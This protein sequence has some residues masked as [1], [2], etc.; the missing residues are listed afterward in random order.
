MNDVYKVYISFK[1]VVYEKIL[2]FWT[3]QKQ[4]LSIRWPCFVR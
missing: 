3:S 4:E 1:L 2:K